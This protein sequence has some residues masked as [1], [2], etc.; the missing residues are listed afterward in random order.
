MYGIGDGTK[1]AVG[2]KLSEGMEVPEELAS[3]FKFGAPKI[4]NW[5]E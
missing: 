4:E 5:P 3:K 2:F 1:R